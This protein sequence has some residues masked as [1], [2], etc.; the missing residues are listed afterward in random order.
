M[1]FLKSE[2]N[3]FTV[4]CGKVSKLIN[5]IIPTKRIERTIVMAIKHIIVYSIHFTGSAKHNPKPLTHNWDSPG[6]FALLTA[7]GVSLPVAAPDGRAIALVFAP[8]PA[9][10]GQIRPP[11]R[12]FG[13]SGSDSAA[14]DITQY[15]DESYPP[16]ATGPVQIAQAALQPGEASTANDLTAWIG[17][18]DV[19]DAL[20]Q[21]H[22]YAAYVDAVIDR[23]AA[24]LS[25]RL[26]SGGADWLATNAV[27]TGSLAIG[28]LPA[29]EALGVP[30][31]ERTAID[32]WRD[33]TRFAACPDGDACIA[34]S[35]SDPARVEH[36]RAILVVGGERLRSGP[37]RQERVTPAQRAEPAQFFEGIN[38]AHLATGAPAFEGADQ[39]TTPDRDQPAT[40]DVIRCLS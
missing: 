23:A 38:A 1:I 3:R 8:G 30:A 24:A 15:L 13:C 37:T 9:L 16:A 32:L 7:D 21:R 28:M 40:A 26:A 12:P 22:D 27:T 2:V 39:F 19:F 14:A 36:C 5:S 25:A 18:D 20:R 11:G 31:G 10:D 17:T 6:Q 35:R 34:V 33:Q 29:A 4:I